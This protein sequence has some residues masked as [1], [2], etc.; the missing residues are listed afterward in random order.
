M[1][2]AGIVL[3][4]PKSLLKI[5]QALFRHQVALVQEQDVA[6]D[7]LGSSHLGVEHV[8]VEIFSINQGD[9]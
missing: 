1:K 9:D 6:I 8:V 4:R 3:H 7:H 5:L 2:N